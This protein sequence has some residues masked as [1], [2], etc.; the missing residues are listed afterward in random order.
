ML[1]NSKELF[2]KLNERLQA[3]DCHLCLTC[4]G[5]FVLNHFEIRATHD[6]DSFYK[7]TPK[8]E[9]IIKNVGDKY[10][11]N[12]EDELWIN[13]SVSNLNKKPP[14]NI[15]DTIYEFS[16]L[17]VMI[18]PL[19]YIAGM[20]F[21]S[22]RE[23]DMRD[24]GSIIQKLQINDP[25]ILENKLVQYG[26]GNIDE[27]MVLEAFGI[28]H[29]MDWLE[30]YYIA[31]QEKIIKKSE[32]GIGCKLPKKKNKAHSLTV[33]NDFAGMKTYENMNDFEFIN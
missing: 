31:N 30:Q 2:E 1:S 9:S 32:N 12:Q 3:E 17:K 24:I 14:E 19:E 18:P 6:I 8:I 25:D 16:N 4:V 22:G 21:N 33:E 23:Q 13:N 11:L 15:C 5:G 20:K 10:N 7:T 27:S 28:A 26:F 29:G